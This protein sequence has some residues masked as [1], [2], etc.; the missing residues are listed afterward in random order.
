VIAHDFLFAMHFSRTNT[1]HFTFHVGKIPEHAMSLLV[2]VVIFSNWK[3]GYWQGI[4]KFEKPKKS[5]G[6]FFVPDGRYESDGIRITVAQ[7]D[8]PGV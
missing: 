1:S 5:N 4:K 2:R 7:A 3:F 6:L 8:G